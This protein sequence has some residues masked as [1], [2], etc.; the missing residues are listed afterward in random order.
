MPDGRTSR[1]RAWARRALLALVPLLGALLLAGHVD[2]TLALLTERTGATSNAFTTATTFCRQ[3]ALSFLTGFEYGPISGLGPFDTAVTTGG[4]PT[5]DATVK[6]SGAYAA[7]IPKSA[8]GA[9]TVT[10]VMTGSVLVTRFAIHLDTLPVGNVA[11]LATVGVTAGSAANLRYNALSK[12]FELAFGTNTVATSA[13]T[14]SAATWYLIDLKVDVASNPRTA[15]WRVDGA[16]QTTASA[17]ES[18]TT[19]S[20]LTVGS[21]TA[22]DVFTSHYD[23]LV[24]STVADAYPIGDGRVLALAPNASPLAGHSGATAFQTEANAA[25]DA[26]AYSRL[27]E[28]PLTSTSDYLKQVTSAGNSYLQVGFADTTSTC[29]NGV[30]ALVA[31][32]A[33]GTS[34]NAATTRVLDGATSTVVHTGSISSSSIVYKSAVVTPASSTWSATALNGIVARIGYSND[35]NPVPYWDAIQLEYDGSSV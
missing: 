5:A 12:K 27:A 33:A 20:A 11:Q 3:P 34:T 35:V 28:V 15:A 16:A 8:L 13:T 25:I 4:S 19:I 26:N 22:A 21:F 10:K 32:H 18:A 30:S 2:P 6:R 14:V 7:K 29:I 9:A 1:T 31:L 17:A 24:A 23:D